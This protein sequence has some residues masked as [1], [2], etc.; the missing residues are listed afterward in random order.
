MTKRKEKRVA[1]RVQVPLAGIV[2]FQA[3]GK[4]LQTLQVVAKDVSEDGTYLWVDTPKIF[5]RVGDKIGINLSCSSD[6]KRVKLSM[7]AV[8]IITR[9]NRPKK[10]QPG[11]GVKFEE[12]P[13]WDKGT[14]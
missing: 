4:G 13:I 3:E 14:G 10:A 7:E 2:T 1:T 11:F 8:G 6:L 12:V 5:P 9:V